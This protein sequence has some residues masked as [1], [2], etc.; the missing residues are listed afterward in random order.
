MESVYGNIHVRGVVYDV[1][2]N[3]GGK[4]LSVNEL[5]SVRVDYD[6]NI[7]KNILRCNTVRVEG[8]SIDRLVLASKIASSYG[9]KI[10]FNPW[11]HEADPASTI[12]YMGEAAEAAEKLKK[13]GADM[14]FVA[15]CEYSLFNLGAIPGSTFDE[16][17]Q[18]I[19]SLGTDPDSAMQKLTDMSV[20]L[21]DIL[22]KINAVVREKFSG[23]VTYSSG[24]WEMVDWSVFD[25][26]GIDYYHGKESDDEYVAGVE[27]Y[28]CDKP[29]FVM[30]MGCCAYKGAGLLG[31]EGFAVFQ[32][33]DGNG[34]PVYRDG[35]TPERSESEQ[36][37]YIEKNIRLLEK[38][39]VDGVCVYLF[40][41]PVY[42]FSKDGIDLDMFS[43]ALVK[44]YPSENQSWN[45]VP[46]WTPKL[47]FY[48]LGTVYS[49]LAGD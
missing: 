1:G 19:T 2:L 30:E 16:R 14:I 38:A 23:K 9:L 42:P 36:A 3:F 27:R 39:G 25:I 18:W 10:L 31:S 47:A 32:G 35:Q 7:I 34:Q 46:S 49:E 17:F 15:G 33:I 22:S 6:M 48:R 8:E 43:Y 5:D 13:E 45:S 29:V 4:T 41:F 40:S 24:T 20:S 28:R 44:S 21:N 11:L 12:Q 26:V 37:D